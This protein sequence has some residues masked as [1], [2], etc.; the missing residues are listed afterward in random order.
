VPLRKMTLEKV[1]LEK[2]RRMQQMGRRGND[3]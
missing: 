3:E 2:V 1:T